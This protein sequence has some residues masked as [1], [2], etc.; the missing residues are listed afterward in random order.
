M[1]DPTAEL[2][3]LPAPGE[4]RYSSLA[5]VNTVIALPA[6]RFVDLLDTV[7]AARRWLTE[8]DLAP[9]DTDMRQMRASRL[10]ALREQVRALFAART[11]GLPAPP[12]ALSAVNDELTR[13]PTAPLLLWEDTS[14][15]YRATPRPTTRILD[16]ALATLA[17]DA[18]D[19]LTSAD[20]QRLTACGSAPCNRYL[21]RH[22]RRHW[23][24][25][26]CGDRARAARA[27]ARRSGT[28]TE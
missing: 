20:A 25:T 6:G 28:G 3:L 10:R 26:R 9:A 17:A 19:L 2:E 22:G 24:S 18:A 14:G 1:E 5:L 15:P 4:E 12:A 23:C 27:Y 21:V 11:R 8:H 13:V 16:H 7:P